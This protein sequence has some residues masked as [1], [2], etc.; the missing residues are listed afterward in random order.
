MESLNP[1]GASRLPWNNAHKDDPHLQ[2]F[3]RDLDTYTPRDQGLPVSRRSLRHKPNT[4]DDFLRILEE[5]RL[6]Y[7]ADKQMQEGEFHVDTSVS[8]L[9]HMYADLELAKTLSLQS[10]P[11]SALLAP[12]TTPP[13]QQIPHSS[14]GLA[15]LVHAE[16]GTDY[17]LKN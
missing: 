15:H 3:L 13:V 9:I 12:P 2:R 1:L 4:D 17:S 14:V 6:E 11:P 7:Q 5:S 10:P 16:Q 8:Y